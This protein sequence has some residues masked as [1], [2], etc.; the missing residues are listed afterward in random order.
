MALSVVLL[1]Y[2]EAENLKNLLPRI[3]KIIEGMKVEYDIFIID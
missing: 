3:N 2:N 1:A